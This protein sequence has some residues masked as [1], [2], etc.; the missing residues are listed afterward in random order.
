MLSGLS[1]IL[2]FLTSHNLLLTGGIKQ[3]PMRHTI[4]GN[5][6]QHHLTEFAIVAAGV[7]AVARMQ[8]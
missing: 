4:G 3:V 1:V 5:H 6:V 8:D 7:V 2:A